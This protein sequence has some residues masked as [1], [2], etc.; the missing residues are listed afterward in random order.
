MAG[1]T[2]RNYSYSNVQRSADGSRVR[3]TGRSVVSTG[4]RIVVGNPGT[5]IGAVDPT[6]IKAL[7]DAA[8]Q[9]AG[10][11]L[12]GAQNQLGVAQQRT[13]QQV[14]SG[15]SMGREQI[16]AL[17]QKMAAERGWTG[18]LW[19]ALDRLEMKEAGYNP[20]AQNPTS[21][22]F[23]LGQFLNSTWGA[24][25]HKKT[26]DPLGQIQAMYDYI[27][28]RYGDPSKALNFHLRNNWY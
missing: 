3:S 19:N 17:M 28:K 8:K 7:V 10:V 24:Y 1:L 2:N 11:S 16:K 18:N 27:A 9:R 23:G 4:N 14:A 21:T 13:T 20:L 26:S 12:Q 25:G 15:L 22:A 5:G 6:R